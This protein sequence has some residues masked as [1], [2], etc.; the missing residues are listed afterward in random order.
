MKALFG[1]PFLLSKSKSAG[2][3]DHRLSACTFRSDPD[4]AVALEPVPKDA[5]DGFR[6]RLVILLR[7]KLIERR[8]QVVVEANADHLTFSRWGWAALLFLC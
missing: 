7:G 3:V 5:A 6:S 4:V 8:K 2:K 1:A